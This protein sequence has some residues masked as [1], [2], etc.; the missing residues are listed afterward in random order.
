MTLCL[1]PNLL[2]YDKTDIPETNR[3]VEINCKVS[4]VLFGSDATSWVEIS[5]NPSRCR[6]FIVFGTLPWCSLKCYVAR[7]SVWNYHHD[8]IKWKH[9]PRYWPFVRGNHRSLVDSSHKGQCWGALMFILSA[10]EKAVEQAI[11]TPVIW[12]AI[13][14]IITSL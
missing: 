12:E 10:S 11:E 3:A 13:A 2:L 14:Y 5:I 4:I 9:F 1:S 8:V 6:C 7:G